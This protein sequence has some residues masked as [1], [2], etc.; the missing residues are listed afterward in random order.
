ME[1]QTILASMDDQE[2]SRYNNWTK[3]QVYEAFISENR[4]RVNL[5]KEVAK[6]TRELVRLKYDIKIALGEK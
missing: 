4:A 2:L 3:E 6:L 5:S 1:D